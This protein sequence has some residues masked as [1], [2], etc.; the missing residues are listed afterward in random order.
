VLAEAA[1]VL[2]PGR[3]LALTEIVVDDELFDA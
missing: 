3:R 1:C 2:R